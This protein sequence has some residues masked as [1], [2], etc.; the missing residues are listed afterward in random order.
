M[1]KLLAL[2]T[3]VISNAWTVG[4]L[5]GKTEEYPLAGWISGTV[6]DS[7]HRRP[8]VGAIVRL[9]PGDRRATTDSNGAYRFDGLAS[10]TYTASVTHR[11]LLAVGDSLVR[12]GISVVSGEE[13]MVNLSTPTPQEL[14]GHFCPQGVANGHAVLLGRVVRAEAGKP[15]QR[16]EVVFLHE[17]AGA[18]P[19]S[20][21]VEKASASVD[22][23]GY[24][25]FC[26]LPTVFYG[27]VYATFEGRST[28]Q[29]VAQDLGSGIDAVFFMVGSSST[30]VR[31]RVADVHGNPVA[32]ALI[33]AQGS[34]REAQSASDGTFLLDSVSIGTQRLVV[35]KMG[36]AATEILADVGV[37]GERLEVTLP[38][39]P[40][41]MPTVEVSAP[42]LAKGLV[43]VGF[44]KRRAEGKGFFM[45]RAQ[46]PQ[47]RGIQLAEV[48]QNVP[49]LRVEMDFNAD[50]RKHG[51]K[52]SYGAR[53]L[54]SPCILIDGL[55]ENM[56][57]I[58]QSVTRKQLSA[59][60]VYE[61]GMAPARFKNHCGTSIPTVVIWTRWRTDDWDGK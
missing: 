33:E 16:A 17:I 42:P 46:F 58:Y 52:I 53:R 48:F 55:P 54:A 29:L 12:T 2:A 60:E 39:I 4:V 51:L 34:Q 3:V 24:F 25:A 41:A 13:A 47:T 7:I 43:D 26:S 45:T 23:Q 32:N 8:L 36:Y 44:D 40:N 5:A 19:D 21:R 59:V 20:D 56:D 61:P 9:T 37:D 22:S 38:R 11:V 6:F 57:V 49:N 50:P 18:T 14:F 30:R 28:A 31:G 27:R 1:R 35:R 15:A 10:G